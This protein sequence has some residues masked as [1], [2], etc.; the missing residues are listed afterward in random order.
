VCRGYRYGT[1]LVDLDT[2]RL[3]DLLPDREAATVAAWLTR[4]PKSTADSAGRRCYLGRAS[5]PTRP[6]PCCRTLT[7]DWP[8]CRQALVRSAASAS[9]EGG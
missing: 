8:R 6:V 7:M 9:T 4:H 1:V 2:H 3:I 5:T